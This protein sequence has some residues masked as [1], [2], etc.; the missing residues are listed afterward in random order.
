[1]PKEDICCLNIK[2]PWNV[3]AGSWYKNNSLAAHAYAKPYLDF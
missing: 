1:M 3:V 2:N